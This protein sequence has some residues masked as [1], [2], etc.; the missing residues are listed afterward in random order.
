MEKLP[1]EARF[2]LEVNEEFNYIG[3]RD[4]ILSNTY[5]PGR[6]IGRFMRSFPNGFTDVYFYN[7][8]KGKDIC[9]F[10]RVTLKK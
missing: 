5:S 9:F 2:D 7:R 3:N 4:V 8:I 6:N 1:L 10:S